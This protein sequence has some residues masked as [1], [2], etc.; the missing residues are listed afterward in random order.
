IHDIL[1]R[2]AEHRPE[3]STAGSGDGDDDGN[4]QH[5]WSKENLRSKNDLVELMKSSGNRQGTTGNFF[6]Y[7][8]VGQQP[9]SA[10]SKEFLQLLRSKYFQFQQQ[11]GLAVPQENQDTNQANINNGDHNAHS[12]N[13]VPRTDSPEGSSSSRSTDDPLGTLETSGSETNERNTDSPP[14]DRVEISHPTLNQGDKEKSDRIE[15]TTESEKQVPKS[16]EDQINSEEQIQTEA[17]VNHPAPSSPSSSEEH[18]LVIDD[19]VD[20]CVDD[21]DIT[22]RPQTHET[23][24]LNDHT[25]NTDD[26]ASSPAMP[27]DCQDE[28]G[29]SHAVAMEDIEYVAGT[30]PSPSVDEEN[31]DVYGSD[32]E[33]GDAKGKTSKDDE[34]SHFTVVNIAMDQAL[35]AAKALCLRCT[36]GSS[37]DTCSIDSEGAFTKSPKKPSKDQSSGATGKTVENKSTFE[38][39]EDKEQTNDLTK[40]TVE[41]KENNKDDDD[42]LPKKRRKTGDENRKDDLSRKRR[43]NSD[44]ERQNDDLSKKRRKTVEE[45]RDDAPNLPESIVTE[46]NA[47][48]EPKTPSITTPEV[49]STGENIQKDAQSSE[50]P[51]LELSSNE[52]SPKGASQQSSTVESQISEPNQASAQV[53]IA[54]INNITREG[55]KN[56]NCSTAV[57]SRTNAN[58]KSQTLINIEGINSITAL[59]TKEPS[60]PLATKEAAANEVDT[61]ELVA[62]GVPSSHVPL[63][64]NANA[65]N[66]DN[67]ETRT[68]T[69]VTDSEASIDSAGTKSGSADTVTTAQVR[70]E[71]VEVSQKESG[72]EVPSVQV[73]VVS[74]ISEAPCVQVPSVPEAISVQATRV[75]S[76]PEAISVQ[77]TRVPSVSEAPSV[78][79]TSV[80]E[81]S[82]VQT[83]NITE[84]R[85]V[86]DISVS[87]AP[88]VPEGQNVLV[89][90]AFDAPSV[91]EAASVSQVPNIPEATSTLE[92]PSVS[93]MLRAPAAPNV[94]VTSS[95][96]ILD[97]VSYYINNN[98][99]DSDDYPVLSIPERSTTSLTSVEVSSSEAACVSNQFTVVVGN[100]TGQPGSP[101]LPNPPVASAIPPPPVAASATDLPTTA[102]HASSIE[103]A[104]SAIETSRVTDPTNSSSESNVQ[105]VSTVTLEI[106][107]LQSS[108]TQGLASAISN[109]TATTMAISNQDD[110]EDVPVIR[111]RT[112][113]FDPKSPDST[114]EAVS[115]ETPNESLTQPLP[116]VSEANTTAQSEANTTTQ[117]EANT[118]TQSEANTTTQS[119]ANTTTQSEAVLNATLIEI[120]QQ[121]LPTLTSY[122]MD[123]SKFHE[124][125]QSFVNEGASASIAERINFGQKYKTMVALGQRS[126]SYNEL[127]DR[128]FSALKAKEPRLNMQPYAGALMTDPDL[129]V[130]AMSDYFELMMEAHQLAK[131][132]LNQ[133][134]KLVIEMLQY[135]LERIV[136]YFMFAKDKNVSEQRF[137][138]VFSNLMK[139][140][141]FQKYS[142]PMAIC[143][144]YWDRLRVHGG[145]VDCK[146]GILDHN[147]TGVDGFRFRMKKMLELHKKDILAGANGAQ[148]SASPSTTAPSAAAGS[149]LVPVATATSAT[150][151]NA[152]STSLSQPQHN[153]QNGVQSTVN[154]QMQMQQYTQQL[155]NTEAQARPVQYSTQH[156]GNYQQQQPQ[157]YQQ[158]QQVQ[159]IQQVLRQQQQLHQMVQQ[160]QQQQVLRQQQQLHQMVQYQPQQV[161][162]SQQRING[163]QDAEVVCLGM[164]TPP[165]QSSPVAS[166]S[167]TSVQQQTQQSNNVLQNANY[168]QPTI[169]IHYDGVQIGQ[170]EFYGPPPTVQNTNPGNTHV[171]AHQV[172]PAATGQ[173]NAGQAGGADTFERLTLHQLLQLDPDQR[174]NNFRGSNPG[175]VV[176]AQQQPNASSGKRARATSNDGSRTSS[177]NTIGPVQ[178]GRVATPTIP[179]ITTVQ[180][181]YVAQNCNAQQ[182]QMP[183]NQAGVGALSGQAAL[184]NQ[185]QQRRIMNQQ[186]PINQMNQQQQRLAMSTLQA[187]QQRAAM[188]ASQ[189]NQ[190]RMTTAQPN[191][192]RA[193][194]STTQAT[195]QPQQIYGYAAPVRTPAAAA[196][197]PQAVRGSSAYASQNQTWT[198]QGTY[199]QST[200]NTQNQSANY[201]TWPRNN[202]V[203]Q[204]ATSASMGMTAQS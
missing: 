27:D 67:E 158:N 182:V 74:S 49:E 185:L 197:N 41:E 196:G 28:D 51:P 121:Q 12:P 161:Q 38:K 104:T 43:R 202:Q 138:N 164:V 90:S 136:H 201:G 24:N 57:A 81:A 106:D 64:I 174:G 100:G 146:Y 125:L 126:L 98:L 40:K 179:Q 190:Q 5:N 153:M 151:D 191:Q 1:R 129:T 79:A 115:S 159:Q 11:R 175:G 198:G 69:T 21:S 16:S 176:R 99:M 166:P 124:Q 171:P 10:A 150:I 15:V 184:R 102:Q 37:D 204:P 42:K 78:P 62:S 105:T 127:L 139:R 4:K 85:S 96:G 39:Y 17:S 46:K 111:V 195:I 130:D 142:N 132:C 18:E 113:I 71:I 68:E 29:D 148:G 13:S 110:Y 89:A 93:E 154:S 47:T 135:K 72:P 19:D 35:V 152:A 2:K 87:E 145:H 84:A 61:N 95:S 88:S 44:D 183:V 31:I 22:D 143:R 26:E 156:M 86:Q 45:T 32:Y 77:A 53:P 170:T 168:Q 131:V 134:R 193:T 123:M 172:A 165:V 194:M 34:F 92:A 122:L 200:T 107:T 3:M 30:V 137:V 108:E 157:Q 163:Q 120:L 116:T 50:P 63:V 55:G 192:H 112:D 8:K 76:V 133:K 91:A 167:T 82:S 162:M 25:H 188:S 149:S 186:V 36:T 66:A 59:A 119:E 140:P 94:Q 180:G 54:S 178:R 187:N 75:P 83:T 20:I 147:V 80:T 118:T 60:A 65:G 181:N 155:S 101:R 23:L 70:K 7:N 169:M 97:P 160:Q 56:S 9:L 103:Q 48:T 117:S 14:N 109:E 73:P 189:A 58:K 141:S 199:Q 203:A 52:V 114:P 33:T 144:A 177:E 6:I 128:S 173:Q